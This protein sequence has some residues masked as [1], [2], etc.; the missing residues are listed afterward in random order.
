MAPL[1]IHKKYLPR[2]LFATVA[3]LVILATAKNFFTRAELSIPVFLI[4]SMNSDLGETE[5]EK[6]RSLLRL[7]PSDNNFHELE[8]RDT[9][10]IK[11][12]PSLLTQLDNTSGANFQGWHLFKL[13]TPY[14][15]HKKDLR[16]ILEESFTGERRAEALRSVIVV[17]DL[18]V[19]YPNTTQDS[20]DKHFEDNL[21]FIQDNFGGIGLLVSVI[22]ETRLRNYGNAIQDNL[23][24]RKTFYY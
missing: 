19:R 9:L 22:E 11:D 8:E 13:D 16:Q 10:I 7:D 14:A 17:L 5:K 12:I 23:V 21:I 20:Q 15:F 2:I 1:S 24:T 3:L 18:D 6:L 4:Y